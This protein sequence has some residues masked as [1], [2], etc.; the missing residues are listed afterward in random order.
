MSPPESLLSDFL[1]SLAESMEV[2]SVSLS[3][4]Q[5]EARLSEYINTSQIDEDPKLLLEGWEPLLRKARLVVD[6]IVHYSIAR[7]TL[8]ID[9]IP[10]VDQMEY[11]ADALTNNLQQVLVNRIH[12]LDPRELEKLVEYTFQSVP[13]TMGIARMMET[14]DG[15]LDFTGSDV[16]QKSGLK[17]RLFGQVKHQRKPISAGEAREF[18]GMIATS[19]RNSPCCG[20]YVST[21][22]FSSDAL[23]TFK[24]SS[25][26]IISFDLNGLVKL[27]IENR[28]GVRPFVI[29]GLVIDEGMWTEIT[30]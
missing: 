29:E 8:R 25:V 27:L 10:S 9:R 2:S 21:S 12:N 1:K 5:L 6:C 20:V 19:G 3:K 11:F 24:K 30:G 16:D 28:V 18:L 22:G 15:G 14:R 7:E 4:E 17:L 23:E 26:R 13:W